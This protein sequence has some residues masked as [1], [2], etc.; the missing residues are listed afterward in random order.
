MAWRCVDKLHRIYFN[1][2]LISKPKIGNI[3]ISAMSLIRKFGSFGGIVPKITH[4]LNFQR[5]NS[6]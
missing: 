4:I 6:A 5:W 1:K 2:E 3:T